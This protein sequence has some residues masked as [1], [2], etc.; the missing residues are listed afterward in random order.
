[1]SSMTRSLTPTI[2]TTSDEMAIAKLTARQWGALSL[3]YGTHPSGTTTK[4]NT[5]FPR[6]TS[7]DFETC[8]RSYH[9]FKRCA[10]HRE[11]EG[12]SCSSALRSFARTVPWANARFVR[13]IRNYAL[14]RLNDMGCYQ[15]GRSNTT[16][17]K[18]S[19][20]ERAGDVL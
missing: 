12:F 6:S 7:A 18:T 14:C 10:E 9:L 20:R 4:A 2:D 8:S 15:L 13:S 11:T 16:D 1:M 3:M 17:F 19:N 5:S